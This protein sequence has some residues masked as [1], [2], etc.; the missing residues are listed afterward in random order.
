MPDPPET[1]TPTLPEQPVRVTLVGETVSG[2]LGVGQVPVAVPVV[3]TDT[4]VL[5]VPS[6]TV[7]VAPAVGA[8]GLTRRTVSTDPEMAALTLPLLEAAL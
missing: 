6:D 8:E 7:I 1:F 2:P 5:E 3:L 4:V